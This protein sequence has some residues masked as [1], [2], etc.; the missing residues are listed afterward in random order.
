MFIFSSSSSQSN[1][2]L[3]KNL[4]R[5]HYEKWETLWVFP[6]KSLAFSCDKKIQHCEP[7]DTNWKKHFSKWKT[8]ARRENWQTVF[9]FF[10]SHCLSW[11][12]S[13]V[14]LQKRAREAVKKKNNN[15]SNRNESE[16]N[17]LF[18]HRF[19]THN[20][21]HILPNKKLKKALFSRDSESS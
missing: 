11:F 16:P 17:P 13:I 4:M 12:V 9:Q 7:S 8:R 15:N 6:W 10:F 5:M 18:D 20:V 2:I 21:I 1:W 14:N 3:E 19:Q